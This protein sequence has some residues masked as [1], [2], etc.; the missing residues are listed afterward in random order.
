MN[1]NKQISDILYFLDSGRYDEFYSKLAEVRL[2]ERHRFFM[3]VRKLLKLEKR[4]DDLVEERKFDEVM[5]GKTDN[6][7]TVRKEKIIN[8]R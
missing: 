5:I 8:T 4:I 3:H 6:L 2:D 1:G 7:L